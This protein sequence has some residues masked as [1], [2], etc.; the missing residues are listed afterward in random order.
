MICS[1]C[2]STEF[3][4]NGH[5]PDGR[6]RWQCKVCGREQVKKPS[7]D[8]NSGETYFYSGLS[9]TREGRCGSPLT[10][11]L[12]GETQEREMACL[13]TA[14]TDLLKYFP[15]D[16]QGKILEFAVKRENQGYKDTENIVYTLRRLVEVGANLYDPE[17]VKTVLKVSRIQDSTK[18]LYAQHY[19][20]FLSF[21]GGKWERP[22]YRI[23]QKIPFIPLESELDQI[24]ASL[25]LKLAAF[26][27]ALKETGARKGEIAALRWTDIDFERR[28]LFINNPEK[29]SLPRVKRASDKLIAML[30][31]FPRKSDAVFG[32]KET[33][34]NIYYRRRKKLAFK[35]SNPRL[36][37]IGLHTFRHWV[38]TTEYHKTKDIIHV[39]KVL[40]HKNIKSTMIY[41]TIEETLFASAPDEFTSK[42]AH[43]V[44]EACQLV[45]TGF[46][47]VCDFDGVK[48]FRKRK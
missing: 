33:I 35:L 12:D 47:Y 42:V 38:G 20:A 32:N 11:G 15:T 3:Y 22:I 18:H 14:K 36:L 43:S 48:I 6:Q 40:G 28:I 31:L 44:E 46:E 2:G 37:K 24:I 27:Q 8:L 9:R 13:E 19:E 25:P 5:K 10:S 39:Q 16:I 45:E 4:K 23:Q 7:S 26:C 29:G 30:N 17:T 41:I 1:R 34:K 21:L